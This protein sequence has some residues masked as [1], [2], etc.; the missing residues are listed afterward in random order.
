[1]SFFMNLIK[2]M[3]LGF[4]SEESYRADL[5]RW[6][7]AEYGREWQWAYQHMID[8]PGAIPKHSGVTL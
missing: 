5:M 1:M 4:R 2:L 3:A 6:A 7:K 8:H